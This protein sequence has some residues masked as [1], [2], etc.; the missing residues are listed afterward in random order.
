MCK[1]L[2]GLDL[3][4]VYGASIDVDEHVILLKMLIL[5]VTHKMRELPDHNNTFEIYASTDVVT[6]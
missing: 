1:C 4:Q 3:L 2:L 6:D 5:V